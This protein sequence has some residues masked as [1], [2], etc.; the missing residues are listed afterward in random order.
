MTAGPE[1]VIQKKVG[2]KVGDPWKDALKGDG[3]WRD[4]PTAGD[5]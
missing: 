2:R 5:P 1:A 4:E 3:P